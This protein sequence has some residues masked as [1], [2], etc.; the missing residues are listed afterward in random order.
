M[1]KFHSEHAIYLMRILETRPSFLWICACATLNPSHLFL[2]ALESRLLLEKYLLYGG[3][4]ETCHHHIRINVINIFVCI[5]DDLCVSLCAAPSGPPLGFAGSAR[6]SSEIITQWQP[7]LEEHRNGQIL[8]YIIRYRLFGY[9]HSPWTQH[10]VTNEVS[11]NSWSSDYLQFSGIV[12]MPINHQYGVYQGVSFKPRLGY[13]AEPQQALFS[14]HLYSPMR[15]QNWVCSLLNFVYAKFCR[16]CR[17]KGTSWSKISLPG[18]ITFCRSP[19]I[20]TKGLASSVTVSKSKPKKEVRQITLQHI[21]IM[22]TWILLSN[23]LTYLII[24]SSRSSAGERSCF[25][26][27]LNVYSSVLEASEPPEDQWYQSGLQNTSVSR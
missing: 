22:F 20:T 1:W 3:L 6:S 11:H 10:N 5:T 2:L 27:Q 15:P 9:N 12:S 8:G 24:F 13:R 18:R 25:P 7:P 16:F 17:P 14:L 19:L 21:R 23:L 26:L 4:S